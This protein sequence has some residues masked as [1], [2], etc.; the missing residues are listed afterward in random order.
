MKKK[1]WVKALV[2]AIIKGMRKLARV[3][4]KQRIQVVAII[5][6]EVV[7]VRLLKSKGQN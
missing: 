1:P 4:R 6:L 7:A 2:L 3:V 5:K